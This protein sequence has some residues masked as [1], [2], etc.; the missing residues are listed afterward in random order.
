MN[1]KGFTLVE[2]IVTL[3]LLSVVLVFMMNSI[4]KLR[5]SDEKANV[6][7]TLMINQSIISYK[8]N[9]D[10]L[11]HGGISSFS[12]CTST[13][14]TMT[15][16][17]SIVGTINITNSKTLTYTSNGEIIFKRTL[18]DDYEYLNISKNTYTYSDS[19]LKKLSISVVN[20]PKYRIEVYSYLRN[21]N[22]S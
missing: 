12:S 22:E 2:I 3:G 6:D 13:S 16:T 20:Y 9:K 10:I 21:E 4:I 8:I 19:S 7:K 11:S 15:F 14:C 5:T 17:D 18:S 1:K